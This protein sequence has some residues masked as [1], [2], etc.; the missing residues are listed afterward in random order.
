[1]CSASPCRINTTTSI[2]CPACAW[3]KRQPRW[4]FQKTPPVLCLGFWSFRIGMNFLK[5]PR[6]YEI[7]GPIPKLESSKGFGN[8]IECLDI[9]PS[10]DSRSSPVL[11]DKYSMHSLEWYTRKYISAIFP[12]WLSLNIVLCPDDIL[13]IRHFPSLSRALTSVKLLFHVRSWSSSEPE[14]V[15]YRCQLWISN[16]PRNRSLME[17]NPANAVASKN[18]YYSIRSTAQTYTSQKYYP[19]RSLCGY[20]EAL[21]GLIMGFH[22]GN[23]GNFVCSLLRSVRNV[24][25]CAWWFDAK[26]F[27]VIRDHFDTKFGGVWLIPSKWHIKHTLTLDSTT[28][29]KIIDLLCILRFKSSSGQQDP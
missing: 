9:V 29:F 15:V 22:S 16:I 24:S 4:V 7:V 21:R 3:L 2:A 25:P 13:G 19:S 8:T 5:N 23:S 6:L 17:L 1:M 28:Y 27:A 18:R 10:N 26:N 14:C 12:T 11:G 20:R